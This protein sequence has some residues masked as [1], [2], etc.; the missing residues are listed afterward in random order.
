[1]KVQSATLFA[2]LSAVAVSVAVIAG[3][4]VIGSPGEVRLRRFDQ[5][6]AINLTSIATAIA[7]Y[8]QTH[9]TLP[10][11]LE[12]LQQSQQFANF[13]LTDPLGRPYEYN[14]KDAFSY[15]LCAQFDTATD[16]SAEPVRT[17]F[18]KHGAGRQCFSREA[19]PRVQR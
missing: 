13:S 4:V 17:V 15:E 8:R 10:A 7:A 19:R 9:E 14:V 2:A 5:T 11:K 3:L 16:R 18:E 12:E 6:R 1:M